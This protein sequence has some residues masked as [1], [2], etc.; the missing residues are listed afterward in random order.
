MLVA[1]RCADAIATHEFQPADSLPCSR[2]CSAL[3]MLSSFR[4]AL[5]SS[6]TAPSQPMNAWASLRLTRNF[7]QRRSSSRGRRRASAIATHEFQHNESLRF[8][9]CS[10]KLRVLASRSIAS[11]CAATIATHEFQLADSLPCSRCCSA[12]RM[13]SSFR[14]AFASSSTAP[15]QL[16]NA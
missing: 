6:S 12:L 8:I 1:S 15:S 10:S 4:W 5:A 11:R 14:W 7:K 13:L 3:R 9:K 16:M 2:C